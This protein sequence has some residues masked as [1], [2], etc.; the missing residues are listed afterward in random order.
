MAKNLIFWK[1]AYKKNFGFFG[2][3]RASSLFY[4]Y[5]RLTCC[6]K[7]EFLWILSLYVQCYYWRICGILSRNETVYKHSFHIS[8]IHN[9]WIA[10]MITS[11]ETLPL[12]VYSPI[13]V[14]HNEL[15]NKQTLPFYRRGVTILATLAVTEVARSTL[16]IIIDICVWIYRKMCF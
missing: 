10:F 9:S 3:N 6:K 7:S 11:R 15:R 1:I 2:E 14:C 5:N 16:D 12:C 4:T 8:Y 13:S